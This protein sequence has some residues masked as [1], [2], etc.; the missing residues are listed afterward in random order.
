MRNE[1]STFLPPRENYGSPLGPPKSTPG[2]PGPENLFLNKNMKRTQITYIKILF[3]IVAASLEGMP[4]L[5]R[6]R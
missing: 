3:L 1:I 4:L 6:R 5:A 2:A